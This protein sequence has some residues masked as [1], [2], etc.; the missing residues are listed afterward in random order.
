MRRRLLALLL[1]LALCAVV[2]PPVTAEAASLAKPDLAPTPPMGWNS[3]N[4]FACD[5]NEALI[6][7]TADAMVSS[8]MAAAG[9]EYVNIDDCWMAPQ[10]DGSGRLQ[11]DPVRFPSGIKAIADYVHARG[12]KLGIYSSAGSHTCQGLP[13]SL[14]HET[15]DAQSWASWGVDLLKYDNCGEQNGI[16]ATTRYKTMADALQATGRPILY[17]ICEWGQNQPWLWGANAGGHMWRTTG[18]IA[19]NWS[20]VMSLLDQQVGLEQYSGPNAWN[21]PDMLEVG[22]SGL[23]Y[24]ESRAHMSL[25]S[26]INS[27][28][29][30]GNDLRSMPASTRDLLTDPDVVAVNQDWAGRQGAKLRDDGDVEVWSKKLSDGSAAV[31]LLNRS[32][33]VTTISTTA[34]ALGLP[35]A[36]AYT[37]KELWSNAVR[38]SAVNVRAQVGAH[39]AAMFRVTPGAAA[40]VAPMVVPEA[41]P[42]KAYVST[43][44]RVDVQTQLHNDGPTAVTGAQIS[45]T[46]PAPWTATPDGPTQLGTVG[47]GQTGSVTWHLAA[48][49]PALGPVALTTNASW[50]WNGSAQSASGAGRFVVANPPAVGRTTLSDGPWVFADNGWGPVERN[51]SVG[52]QAAGDGKPLTVAGTVYP[53]GLGTH[54]PGRIGYFL[55]AQCTQLTTKVGIDDEV[56]D[57]GEVQFEIWGDGTRLAQATATGAGGAVT[58][59]ANLTGVQVVELV[60]DPKGSPDF[61]HADWL[62]PELTCVG[63]PPP[64]GKSKLAD[65]PWTSMSNG[66]GPVER[67]RSNGEQPAGDG[68]PLTVAGSVYPSGLGAHANGSITFHLGKR[69]SSLTMSVGIDDEV[70]DRGQVHFEVWGDGTRLAQADATGAGAVVPLTAD[71][72]N[73]TTLDL[74]LDSAGSVDFDHAD[75]LSPEVTCT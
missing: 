1:S 40:D 41:V 23:T 75:W 29:I 57:R 61:D 22:N 71:L 4:T 53:K 34:S 30:A 24:A 52:E 19:N 28:L 11:A 8:G 36:S 50:T 74:R 32:P 25:W 58:L 9:Y 3:W 21:D 2:S 66:W 12:L 49:Q 16:P 59:N 51:L 7:D 14:G 39:D 64:V 43:E 62:A 35:A 55:D 33:N 73:V 46:A 15:V 42:T 13:A 26:I 63:T 17:S 37:V 60:V 54:A 38:A 72:T 44:G 69:C 70:G 45:L 18:D 20:S 6:R 27:P 56:A 68:Q 5:I 67:N 10:R 31:V 65:R 47:A 48:N